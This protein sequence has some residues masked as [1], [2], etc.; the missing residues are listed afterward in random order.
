MTLLLRNRR[1]GEVID[2]GS[3]LLACGQTLGERYDVVEPKPS[4]IRGGHQ[5]GGT[6]APRNPPHAG[7]TGTAE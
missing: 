5:P 7:P 4:V 1:T 3:V 6:G 2:G